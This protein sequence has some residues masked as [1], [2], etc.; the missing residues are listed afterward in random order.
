[1]PRASIY[2]Y[3]KAWYV[4]DE[5]Y[6]GIPWVEGSGGQGALFANDGDVIS[7][8]NTSGLS[9]DSESLAGY[10]LRDAG[11]NLPSFPSDARN[12]S[13]K[14]SVCG[15]ATAGN[16]QIAGGYLN[17]VNGKFYSASNFAAFD[18]NN[19]WHDKLVDNIDGSGVFAAASA[20][21]YEIRMLW[22]SRPATDGNTGVSMN[23][24][25]MRIDYDYG[26]D[27]VPDQFVF[28]DSAVAASSAAQSNIVTITGADAG[29][30]MGGIM[31]SASGSMIITV[32]GG[33]S[34][35]PGT[36]FTVYN[37]DTMQMQGTAPPTLGQ[38]Y[39]ATVT[40]NGVSDEWEILAGND[41]P[42][43]VLTP[44]SITNAVPS[45]WYP[46]NNYGPSKLLD[47]A[48]QILGHTTPLKFHFADNPHMAWAYEQNGPY[49]DS[50][51]HGELPASPSVVVSIWLRIKAPE[52][53]NS[54]NT[55][56]LYYSSQNIASSVTC[57]TG[58][59]SVVHYMDLS[60]T[61][62]MQFN[63][64]G[65]T[66]TWSPAATGTGRHVVVRSPMSQCALTYQGASLVSNTDAGQWWRNYTDGGRPI[67]PIG[68]KLVGVDYGANY[69][70]SAYY[71]DNSNDY[72]RMI[73]SVGGRDGSTVYNAGQWP[74]NGLGGGSSVTV[75]AYNASVAPPGDWTP[76][77]LLDAVKNDLFTFGAVTT[78]YCNHPYYYEVYARMWALALR[79]YFKVLKP[80]EG[81]AWEA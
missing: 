80:P 25:A 34:Y 21:Q 4:Y 58:D 71:G 8:T 54:V 31:N 14:L 23:A 40:V 65:T 46:D 70:T 63:Y 16:A 27:D 39:S 50:S 33:Q 68:M 18:T 37:G 26:P 78:Q 49:Y 41:V 38:T 6:Y 81:M 79:L 5:P 13:V 69:Q 64:P 44:D 30:A 29:V 59:E 72:S 48:W 2:L 56:T 66:T 7:A 51:V 32:N 57:A 74:G 47:Q 3:P 61:N 43:S 20:G 9:N 60:P 17:S 19:R 75:W 77:T 35:G 73:I 67:W 52:Q 28:V 22:A 12:P 42:T 15:K 45:V 36:Q 24:F 62:A 55:V 11:G 10:T 1:M 76:D 53:P